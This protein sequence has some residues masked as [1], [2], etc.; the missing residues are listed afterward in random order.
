MPPTNFSIMCAFK[1]VA[2][3]SLLPGVF[4]CVCRSWP[5]LLKVSETEQRILLS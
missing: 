4:F 1:T 3:E 2:N 5:E